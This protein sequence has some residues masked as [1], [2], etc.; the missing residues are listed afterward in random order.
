MKHHLRHLFPTLGVFLLAFSILGCSQTARVDSP[1][2]Q[3]KAPT[4]VEKPAPVTPVVSVGYVKSPPRGWQAFLADEKGVVKKIDGGASEPISLSPGMWKLMQ[5]GID[6]SASDST[7]VRRSQ[8]P[9]TF[10]IAGG[11]ADTKSLDIRAGEIVDWPYGPPFKA[12][13]DVS[14]A[15]PQLLQLRLCVVGSGGEVWRDLRVD[16][17]RPPAPSFVIKTANDEVIESGEFKWG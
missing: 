7:A 9:S 2:G 12:L 16:G 11:T 4:V 13:V 17:S 6:G 3:A 5:Y 14:R 10:F 1:S 8:G 15:G